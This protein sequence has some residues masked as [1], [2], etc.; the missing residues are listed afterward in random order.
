MLN[1]RLRACAIVLPLLSYGCQSLPPSPELTAPVMTSNCPPPPVPDAWWM[2]PDVPT[3][4][5]ELLND[6]SPSPSAVTAP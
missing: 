5:E 3:L 1:K 4:T 6:L 2:A